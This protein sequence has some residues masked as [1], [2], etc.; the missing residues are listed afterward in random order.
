MAP[1]KPHY[2]W[3]SGHILVVLCAAR[4]ILAW[5]TF[6]SGK[7]SWWYSIALL[8]ALLSYG[9]VVY[10]SLG[11]PKEGVQAWVVRA[12][13]DENFQYLGLAL[14]WFMTK[15]PVP[16][17]L[18]PYLTF[19]AFHV[20]TFIRTTVIPM[21]FPPTVGA[22]GQPQPHHFAKK[23]QVFVKTYYDPSMK[24]VAYVEL[25]IF[26]RVVLGVVILQNS[27]FTPFAYGFFLRQRYYHSLFTRQAFAKLDET[28]KMFLQ[29]PQARGTF[30]NAPAWYDMFK[31]YLA[32]LTFTVIEPAPAP[33]PAPGTAG[34]S[35]TKKTS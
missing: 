27:L 15:P 34:S 19:S 9:I 8:G 29:G 2:A 1:N 3:A 6:K 24:L 18:V 14:F 21:F 22:N 30:P 11:A 16:L 23:I 31:T 5:I 33:A 10:K 13:A 7:S 12:L 28:I 26:A 32:K 17:A 35:G 25:G 4:Y 20:A